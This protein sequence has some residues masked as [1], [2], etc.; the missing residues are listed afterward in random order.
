MI[1]NGI[2]LLT[3]PSGEDDKYLYFTAKTPGF[4][5]FVITGKT[6]ATGTEI[7]PATGN[8]KQSAVDNTQN[9]STTGSK[10]T[11]VE[12]T[13]EQNQ[14]PNTSGKENTKTPGFEI[15]SCIFCLLS[16]FLYKRR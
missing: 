13:P 7:Q 6:K 5:P 1:R 10:A 15:T 4:S 8:K 16:V 3:N 12:Q 2:H 11:S 9:K 14:N